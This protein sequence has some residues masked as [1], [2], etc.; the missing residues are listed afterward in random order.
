[1]TA[2]LCSKLLPLTP[3]WNG[4]YNTKISKCRLLKG[5]HMNVSTFAFVFSKI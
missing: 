1:M 4:E 3:S 2:V 5:V